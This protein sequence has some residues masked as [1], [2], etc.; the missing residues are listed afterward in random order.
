MFD[1]GRS[2]GFMGRVNLQNWDPNRSHEL[3]KAH[4]AGFQPA[5][6]G[7]IRAAQVFCGQGCPQNRQPRWLPYNSAVRGEGETLAAARGTQEHW[8]FRHAAMAVPAGGTRRTLRAL[9]QSRSVLDMPMTA[10]RQKPDTTVELV[11]LRRGPPSPAADL[12]Y[13][14]NSVLSGWAG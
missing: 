5:G 1:V 13:S 2:S 8:I 4:R 6:L 14:V 10:S 12:F 11:A 3:G 9:R 7:G